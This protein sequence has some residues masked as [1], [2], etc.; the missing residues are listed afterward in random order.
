MLS[1]GKNKVYIDLIIIK[2]RDTFVEA[3]YLVSTF[4]NE[5]IFN[6]TSHITNI[7]YCIHVSTVSYYFK[8]VL[9][10]YLVSF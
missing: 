4:E 10:F 2:I 1:Q 7:L 3:Y 9:P 6:T 5:Y 8:R